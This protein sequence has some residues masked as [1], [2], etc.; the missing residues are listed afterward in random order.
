MRV[1]I[2]GGVAAGMSAA[3]RLRRLDEQAEIIVFDR[4]RYVSY[5]SCGLPYHIGGTIEDRQEL[6]VATPEYLHA[7]LAL[8]VRIEHEVLSI[9][10]DAHQVTVRQRAS[11]K[12]TVER[13]DKLVL[14]LG[15]EPLRPP[16]PGID[17]P[18]VL[19]LRSIGDMD[20]IIARIESGAKRAVVIG[21]SYIGVEVIEALHSRGLAVELVELQDQVMPL[22]DREIAAGLREHLEAHGVAVHVGVSARSFS[23]SEGHV[24][25]E[26]SDGR[27]LATDLVI[28]AVGVRPAVGLAKAAGLELGPRGG[29]KVDAQLRTSDPDI[30]A[31]GDMIEVIDTVTGDPAIIALAGPANRQG[32]II[33]DQICGRATSYAS[34]QGTAIVKVFERTAAMTG[35]SEKTLR[36]IGRPYEKVYV[37]PADHAG[38]YPDAE[39]MQ[40]KLLFAPTS[41]ALLGA[42]I[43]GGAGV[44]KR[45]DVLATA[46]RAGLTVFDLEEL[47]LAYAPP[48]AS[49]K[50]PINMAGFTAANLL[51]GD[52]RFW[53]A[54]QYPAQAQDALFV[55]V[56]NPDEYAEWHIPHA[57]NIP[58]PE[59]RHR[60]EELRALA[61]GRLVRLYCMVGFRS[62]LA[63]RALCQAGYADV[64]T[65]AGGART[66]IAYYGSV[67]PI[68]APLA[69]LAAR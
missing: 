31:A 38:Y 14:A 45:I 21:G 34:T 35:A 68:P 25:V 17:L 36:R 44:D 1:L 19:A 59:L 64:A 6:L 24:A 13:Y 15:A 12:Q 11:G 52:V 51:R 47:E 56:R 55:D 9:D 3:A 58:L 10:R 16:I 20:A 30:Y 27:R 60:I 49:A 39:Q 42:Q 22:L 29:L 33:A 66:M 4:D 28:L 5:A 61:D 41:G 40:I 2:V 67:L 32:R 23:E 53:Y 7:N 46:L 57:V 62:Y 8:D 54:E 69:D 50:D 43:I 26:L 63:Y 37:H 65:L 48:Y 18:R